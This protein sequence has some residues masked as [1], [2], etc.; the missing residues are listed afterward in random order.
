MNK[1]V[2]YINKFTGEDVV[3]Q[4][5][6]REMLDDGYLDYHYDLIKRLESEGNYEVVDLESGCEGGGEYCYGVF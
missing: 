2:D 1:V 4:Y 3:D 6:L 5:L